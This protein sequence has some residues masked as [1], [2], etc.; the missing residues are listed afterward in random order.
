ML[1]SIFERSIF[2]T[3]YFSEAVMQLVEFRFEAS[4]PS[5]EDFGE[6]FPQY[7]NYASTEGRL[8]FDLLMSPASLNSATVATAMG[9]AAVT[10]IAESAVQEFVRGG[11]ELTDFDK[12]FIGAVVCSLMEANG[13]EKTGKKRSIPH[14]AFT[15][16]EVYQKIEK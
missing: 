13:Y 1:T 8:V 14:K 11:K 3:S 5:H 6:R 10:G 4:I 16:G 2:M 7:K 15:K 12:Q 9:F